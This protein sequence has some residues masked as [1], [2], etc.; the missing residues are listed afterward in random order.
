MEQFTDTQKR[1]HKINNE[2]QLPSNIVSGDDK[3]NSYVLQY[4]VPTHILLEEMSYSLLS[5]YV[6]SIF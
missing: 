6:P 5:F 4:H 3:F 1:K 2:T